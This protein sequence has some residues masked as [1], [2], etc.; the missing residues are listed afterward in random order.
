LGDSIESLSVER[1]PFREEQFLLALAV[2]ATLRHGRAR[3]LADRT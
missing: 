1:D 2:V 3:H